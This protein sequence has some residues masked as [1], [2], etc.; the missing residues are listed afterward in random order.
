MRYTALH[1][2][3]QAAAAQP[4]PRSSWIVMP[5]LLA[6]LLSGVSWIS[7]GIVMLNDLAWGLVAIASLLFI[8]MELMAFPRRMGVSG[9]V[10]FGATWAWY[11]MDYFKYW[12]GIMGDQSLAGGSVLTAG[13]VSIEVL[14][15][16]CFFHFLFITGMSI[17]LLLP[18][19]NWIIRILIKTPHPQKAGALL[20]LI[21][22]LF[23]FGLL[24]YFLFNSEPF[25]QAVWHQMTAMRS[26][27][28]ASW[29]IGRSAGAM[30]FTWGG[31]V[32]QWLDVGRFAGLIAAFYAI[33]VARAPM[34]KIICWMMWCY[35]FGVAFGT[36]TRGEMLYA[37]APVAGLLF[38]KNQTNL[39]QWA[40]INRIK[41]YVSVFLV[42][43]AMYTAIQVQGVFRNVGLSNA[44]LS[45][46]D[47]SDPRDN[48]IFSTSIFVF[49][50]VPDPVT[51]FFERL[52][53]GQGAFMAIPQAVFYFV[54]GPIPR[55]IWNTKPFNPAFEWASLARTGAANINESTSI[56]TGL[57]GNWY[58]LCGPIGLIEGAILWGWIMGVFDRALWLARWRPLVMVLVLALQ[59][60]IFR[61]FRDPDYNLF[62]PLLIGIAMLWIMNAIIPKQPA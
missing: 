15:K 17:G 9:L 35:T 18:G 28:A 38:I 13:A 40:A 33:Y 32:N 47:F 59:I 14:S 52:F 61:G 56:S 42:F 7:G 2:S 6:T 44:S 19:G 50:K 46:I 51:P 58:A 39:L 31:Y 27:E 60:S 11:V 55:T 54:I 24:P 57:V 62:Y 25:Y 10:L 4:M 16:V 48:V 30:N 23:L 36:G 5:P 29:T 8:F 41:A 37:C 3:A 26:G 45:Q 43:A 20:T 53:P 49:Q 34:T 22:V 12:S 21:I 1:S